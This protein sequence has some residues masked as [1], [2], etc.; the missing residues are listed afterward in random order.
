MSARC[1]GVCLLILSLI[2]TGKVWAQAAP[3]A[4]TAT[5]AS[6]PATS[7]APADALGRTTPRG[8]VRGFLTEAG[9]GDNEGAARYLNTRLPAQTAALLAHEL[10]VV[11]N[12]RLPAKLNEISDKPEGSQPYP[13][14]PDKDLIGTISG[15]AGNV[16]IVVERVER[17]NASAI[18]LFSRKT[19]DQIP[20]LYADV[21]SEPTETGV[22]K[23]LLETKIASIALLHWVAFFIGLPL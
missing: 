20:E 21:E 6:A 2:A 14:E 10:F 13:A 12:R 3:P 19:L 1:S 18:W 16:D 22:L 17:K 8:T 7:E 23:F 9:K 11:L 5:A 4:S 15:E